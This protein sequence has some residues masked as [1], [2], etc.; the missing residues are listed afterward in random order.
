ML[1]RILGEDIDLVQTP[2][3]DLG[4]TLADPSQLEQ[5]LNER[6]RAATPRPRH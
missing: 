3:P 1:Q 5:V 2:A 4:L 6:R